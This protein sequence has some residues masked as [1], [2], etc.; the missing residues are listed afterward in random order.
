MPRGK[1]RGVERGVVRA[2][3]WRRGFGYPGLSLAQVSEVI[4]HEEEEW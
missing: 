1:E 3:G 4:C 2:G